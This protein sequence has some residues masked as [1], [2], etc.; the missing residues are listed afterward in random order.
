MNYKCNS[1]GHIFDEI[2]ATHKEQNIG[3]YWGVLTYE[4]FLCCPKCNGDEIEEVETCIICGEPHVDSEMNYA[5]SGYICNDCLKTATENFQLCL[6]V[7]ESDKES[8]DI[9]SFAA[10]ILGENVINKII[11]SAAIN[12]IKS[13]KSTTKELCSNYIYD[14]VSRFCE[15]WESIHDK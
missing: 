1:C 3:E 4:S 9:N 5:E 6:A 10:N 13:L 12:E 2:D 11:I 7:G 8:I 14:D 15:T